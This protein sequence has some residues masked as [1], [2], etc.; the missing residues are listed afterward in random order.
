[1]QAACQMMTMMV[2]MMNGGVQFPRAGGSPVV[3][4]VPTRPPIASLPWASQKLALP[5]PGPP[6]NEKPAK[7]LP[8][9]EDPAAESSSEEEPAEPPAEEP[10]A[11]PAGMGAGLKQ[12]ALLPLQKPEVLGVAPKSISEMQEEMKKS[13]C[14]EEKASWCCGCSQDCQEEEASQTSSAE[15]SQCRRPD[16]RW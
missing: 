2:N 11:E 9:L 6:A 16:C 15:A 13:A 14:F 10:P 4:M 5:A 1:M 7:P 12:P 8:E 3:K